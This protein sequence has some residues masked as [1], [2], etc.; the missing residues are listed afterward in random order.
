MKTNIYSIVAAGALLLG[1]TSCDGRFDY[2]QEG[3]GNLSLGSMNVTNDDAV[4]LIKNEKSRANDVDLSEYIVKI[5]ESTDEYTPYK[6]YTYGTMPE[7][8]AL[9]K[10]DYI[11]SVESHKVQK[12]EWS[13]PYFVGSKS[14]TINAGKITNVGNVVCEFASIKVTVIFDEKLVEAMGNK[15]DDT[16]VT[17][18]ANEDGSLDFAVNETRAG[19]FQALPTSNTMV[20]TFDG[21][22]YGAKTTERIIL[23]DVA[24]KQHRIITFTT[25]ENPDIPS[26]TGSVNPSGISLD[27]SMTTEDI[28]G[29]VTVEEDLLSGDHKR[30]GDDEEPNDDPI[31]PP[32]PPTPVTEAATFTSS[33]LSLGAD[34]PNTSIPATSV[35]NID[36]PKGF[37]NLLV[38]IIT[39]SDNFRAS[40]SELM[41][42]EFDLATV[43]DPTKSNLA[44]IG[45]PV[46]DEVV[47]KTNVD[48]NITDLAPLLGGFAGTHTF[49]LSVTDQEGNTSILE[50]VFVVK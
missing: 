2:G 22:I 46:G 28:N 30:P 41:P 12:A 6:T 39:T 36:C 38:N 3:E 20:V 33:T 23:T 10:G 26:Q 5:F 50:L 49:K 19:Y 44:S 45:L 43:E 35:V 29:T 15:K 27:V 4:K 16:K 37:K 11:L 14:F 21:Y 8:V 34:K 48:F 31:N 17:I 24:A 25:R 42:M 32:T 18:V 9:P 7:V 47:G 40:V 1:L 13:K